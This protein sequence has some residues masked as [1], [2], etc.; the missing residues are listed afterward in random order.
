[1]GGEEPALYG[2]GRP[3]VG[4]PGIKDVVQTNDRVGVGGAG[5]G[6]VVYNGF[7]VDPGDH[8]L[9]HLVV[10]ARTSVYEV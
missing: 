8:G 1:M 4:G 6:D 3:A 10:E 7:Q 9:L 5:E 2:E